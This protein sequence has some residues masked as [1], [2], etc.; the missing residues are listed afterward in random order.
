[1]VHELRVCAHMHHDTHEN[2]T[3][4]HR[5]LC[6]TATHPMPCARSGVAATAEATEIRVASCVC[7]VIAILSPRARDGRDLRC[8]VRAC[9]RRSTH[10]TQVKRQHS[11]ALRST[12]A[13]KSVMNVP[14]KIQSNRQEAAARPG[15]AEILQRG[16]APQFAGTVTGR[17]RPMASIG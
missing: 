6:R 9:M 16:G 1:M 12:H 14:F 3:S 2:A 4:R 10:S 5:C 7:V 17:R 11:E 15:A 8:G 13:S